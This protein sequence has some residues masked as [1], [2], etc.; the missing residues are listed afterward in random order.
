MVDQ[1]MNSFSF[2]DLFAGIGGFH[3]AL[4]QLGGQCVYASELD[5]FARKTYEANFKNISPSLFEKNLFRGD[6]TLDENQECIPFDVDILCAGFPCQAF[7]IAGLQKGFS[8]SRGTLFFEIAKIL[9]NKQPKSF[10][11]E[12]VRHLL[13]HDDGKTFDVIYNILTKELNYTVYYKIIKASDHGLPTFRPRVY[14][15]GF[16]HDIEKKEEFKFPDSSSLKFTMSDV[17]EGECSRKV[18]KT[19]IVGGRGSRIND[20]RNWDA[21]LVDGQIKVLTL[22][23]AKKMMGYPSDFVFP[24]SNTQALKQLGNSV[25]I[26]PVRAIANNILKI[27]K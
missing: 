6:I 8:D 4:H 23:E 22:K 14:I 25:A 13:K 2:I 10:L 26:D 15:V 21:Y 24:V 1:F 19:I 9:K 27:M 11:L 20:K 3:I 17:F 5:S 12:N 7:S 16:R 18:G